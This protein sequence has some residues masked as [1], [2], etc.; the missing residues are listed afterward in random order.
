MDRIGR[1]LVHGVHV[2][3]LEPD[4]VRVLEL[5]EGVAV[6]LVHAHGEIN[7]TLRMEGMVEPARRETATIDWAEGPI[8]WHVWT[9]VSRVGIAV[10][11][12]HLL[13]EI[14]LGMMDELT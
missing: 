8:Y 9:H 14:C 2:T 5:F 10:Q 6:L 13:W 1:A 7:L 4:A 3:Y 12:Y 11:L